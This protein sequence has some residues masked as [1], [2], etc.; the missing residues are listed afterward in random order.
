MKE[1]L[2][3][4]QS[5]AGRER[6]QGVDSTHLGSSAGRVALCRLRAH[7][8]NKSRGRLNWGRPRALRAARVTAASRVTTSDGLSPGVCRVAQRADALRVAAHFVSPKSPSPDTR[9]FASQCDARGPD[10]SQQRAHC[11]NSR[12]VR[13]AL[14]VVGQAVQIAA[15]DGRIACITVE[16]PLLIRPRPDLRDNTRSS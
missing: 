11:E 2:R 5:L 10:S 7:A 13:A 14:A 9:W 3:S 1:C 15:S 4:G 6:R 8:S 16:T 12:A